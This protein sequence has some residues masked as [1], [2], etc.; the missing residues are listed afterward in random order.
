MDNKLGKYIENLRKCKKLTQKELADQLGLSNTAIS[1]WECGYNLPDISMLDPLSKILDADIMELLRYYSNASQNDELVN[2]DKDN[3]VKI[4]VL[5][6]SIVLLI[7]NAI[8]ISTN[9]FVKLYKKNNSNPDEVK[10]Y[11]IISE[12][13]RINLNGYLIFNEEENLILINKLSYQE[14][15][16]GTPK[17]I[18]A[19]SLKIYLM[20]N[21]DTLYK[22]ETEFENN[23]KQKL[24]DLINEIDLTNSDFYNTE[25]DLSKLEGNFESVILKI[26]YVDEDNNSGELDAKM[27]LKERFIKDDYIEEQTAF[28]LPNFT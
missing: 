25:V 13:E 4:I 22:Y 3:K 21:S 1:K 24:S 15:N 9:L 28:I 6:C 16:R 19:K 7:L 8:I 26:S 20:I 2:N 14:N 27:Q 10:V 23:K 5:V 11:R 12:D 18:Y 17:E